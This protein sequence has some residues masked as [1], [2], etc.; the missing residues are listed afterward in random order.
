M[1]LTPEG[2]RQRAR[3]HDHCPMPAR[4]RTVRSARHRQSAVSGTPA[5]PAP[6]PV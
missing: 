3:L 5:D 1:T 2:R 4:R 6:L